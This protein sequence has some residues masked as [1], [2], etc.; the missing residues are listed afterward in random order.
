VEEKAA[1]IVGDGNITS[2]IDIARPKSWWLD[3]QQVLFKK[4]MNYG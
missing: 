3:T 2:E 1:A 4:E